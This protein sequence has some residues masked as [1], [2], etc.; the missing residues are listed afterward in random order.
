MKNTVLFILV[1]AVVS[2]L[3]GCNI[4]SWTHSKEES[5]IDRGLELMR[6][7]QYAEAEAEF[8]QAMEE[9]PY[10]ADAR[11][12]H[13]KAALSGCSFGIVDLV[14][15]ISQAESDREQDGTELPL[16]SIREIAVADEVYRVNVIIVDDLRP[17]HDGLTHGTITAADIDVDLAVACLVSAILGLRDTN[18]DG[19]IDDGDLLLDI[20][21]SAALEDYSIL[22]LQQFL[23]GG[24]MS[25]PLHI[26]GSAVSPEDINLLIDY[27]LNLIEE[28]ADV[29]VAAVQELTTGLSIDNIRGL[30]DDVRTTITKY[31][32]DDERDNDGDGSIDEE[33]LD[34]L[35]DDGDGLIDED[36]DRV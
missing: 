24:A 6:Q 29:L 2:A 12:H 9:D 33:R 23:G 16:Y 10:S 36:T 32:Y 31:Y 21:Y 35:D 1:I 19:T 25:C 28:S 3:A 11:Y 15:E 22:G 13:A 5:H 17:I 8:A 7:G 14:R 4:L 34:G 27:V 30:L 26:G 20:S 18:R